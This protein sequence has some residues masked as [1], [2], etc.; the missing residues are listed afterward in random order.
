MKTAKQILQEMGYNLPTFDSNGFCERVVS[1]FREKKD[2]SATILLSSKR[3]VEMEAE[4]MEDDISEDAI[5]DLGFDNIEEYKEAYFQKC[6]K[7]EMDK[8]KGWIDVTDEEMWEKMVEDPFEPFDFTNYLVAKNRGLMRPM[9]YIDEPY[10]KNAAQVL[11]LY[12]FICKKRQ[13]N[14]KTEFIVSLI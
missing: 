11:T 12:G 4:K 2:P 14:K 13:R 6:K 1:Y 9:F 8:E 10:I 3:F 5:N 7:I